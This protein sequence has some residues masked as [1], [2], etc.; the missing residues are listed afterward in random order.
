[1]EN[2]WP[3]FGRHLALRVSGAG[4]PPPLLRN[5][6]EISRGMQGTLFPAP[7]QETHYV[8]QVLA[9][10]S[11]PTP[12]A[13]DPSGAQGATPVPAGPGARR[14]LGGPPPRSSSTSPPTRA[15][16]TAW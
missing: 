10:V 8:V 14:G 15:S 1:K 6:R 4:K 16:R 7:I 13:L 3:G 2:L 11:V 5:E 12:S 9:L